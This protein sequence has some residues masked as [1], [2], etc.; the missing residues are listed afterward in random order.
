MSSSYASFPSRP[1]AAGVSWFRYNVTP[2]SMTC[3]F[4]SMSSRPPFL[5]R[6]KVTDAQQGS[7]FPLSTS[8]LTPFLVW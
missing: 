2:L 7:H 1:D 8:D 3:H 6:L 4:V 5:R